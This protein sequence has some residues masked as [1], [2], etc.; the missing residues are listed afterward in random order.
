MNSIAAAAAAAAA[1]GAAAAALGCSYCAAP[2]QPQRPKKLV[3]KYWDG[4]GLA[5]V[6]RQL[7]SIAGVP[8]ED[9]RI[10]DTGGGDPRFDTG[11]HPSTTTRGP[12]VDVMELIGDAALDINLGRVPVLVVDGVSIGQGSSIA[13]YIASTYGLMGSTPV[14]AGQVDSICEAIAELKAAFNK[15]ADK[16]A[17][18]G[19]PNDGTDYTGMAVR[20][21]KTGVRAMKW[22]CGRLERIVGTTGS[23]GCAVGSKISLAV[24]YA[25]SSGHLPV[26]PAVLL[27]H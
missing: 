26:L 17:F 14:E 7:L 24:L 5:E 4:R 8:F 3:L 16:D 22:Y 10:H 6:P 18:F 27:T 21:G 12:T 13:R 9:V 23:P 1:V 15:A 2:Q 19:M 11:Q 20:P 25:R